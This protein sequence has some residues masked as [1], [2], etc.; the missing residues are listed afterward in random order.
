V[1]T[2]NEDEQQKDPTDLKLNVS[3]PDGVFATESVLNLCWGF[4][5]VSVNC[6]LKRA[7]GSLTVNNLIPL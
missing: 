2:I 1:N 5:F 6:L 3:D 7:D 4:Y